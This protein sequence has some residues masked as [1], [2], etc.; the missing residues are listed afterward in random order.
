MRVSRPGG[1]FASG[2]TQPFPAAI[3]ALVVSGFSIAGIAAALLLYAV[4]SLTALVFSRYYLRDGIFPHWLWLLPLRD[5]FAFVTW[6]LAFSGQKVRWR[7][8]LFRLLPG[9]NI[10]ELPEK[11]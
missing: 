7:G 3:L 6:L 2:L 10:V 9:G 11:K 8:N 1:Y 5:L 4:R